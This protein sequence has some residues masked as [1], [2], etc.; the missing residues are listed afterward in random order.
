MYWSRTGSLAD[1]ALWCLMSGLWWVGGW[2]LVTHVF[3]LKPRERLVS[4]LAAGLLL[5]LVLANLLAHFLPLPLTFWLASGLILSAGLGAAA[6]RGRDGQVSPSG[7]LDR[8]DLHAWPLL[9]ALFSLTFLFL[10]IG[11][12]LALFDDYLHL[13]LISVMAA[14][15][16]PPPFYLNPAM[17]MAYHYGLQILAASL[18]RTG[19][20]FPW[21]AWDAS[22]AL[23]IALTLALGWLWVRRIT[24]SQVGATLGAFL[25]TFAG[26]ARWLLL[27]VPPG[28]LLW[29]SNGVQLSNTGADTAPN[30]LKAL[31][32]PWLIDGGGPFP[33]PFAFHNGIFIPVFFELGGTGAIH[34]ATVL[35]LLLLATRH[36]FSAPALLI[37]SLIFAS[38]ALTAE[39]LFVFLWGGIFLAGLLY[40]IANRKQ[41]RRRDHRLLAGWAVILALSGILSVT[42][43]AYLTQAAHSFLLRL[44][45][46]MPAQQGPY[47]YFYFTPRWPPGL[48]SAHLGELSWFNPRQLPVL[49][50]ELGPALWLAPLV[51]I[52]AWRALRRQDWLVAGL[53]IAGL[54]S[55]LVPVFFRY[56][57]ERSATRL[58]ATALWLFVVL[59]F[60]LLWQ[61]YRRARTGARFWLGL[62]YGLAVLGGIVIF[63][64]ELI[65][66]PTPQLTTFISPADALWS[67]MYWRRLPQNSLVFDP[68]SF[69]SVTLF[70]EP[71]LANEGIYTPLPQWEALAEQ[72]DPIA[73]AQAGYDFLYLDERW[74]RHMT[75]N[76]Q[77]AY[78]QPCIRAMPGPSPAEFPRLLD[79]RNC[80]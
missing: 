62:G 8:Q 48:T 15:E 40:W 74:W 58:P 11:R 27:L 68:I 44:Q 5:F 43:G 47:D 65:A 17:P 36:D 1:L 70:G 59:S 63:A 33:F 49:L 18:V 10:L 76:E 23:A 16:I 46:Q 45:G 37:L 56:G 4:G 30:L 34:F 14:G 53:G 3:R 55:L 79:L 29:M 73:I 60:P 50:A 13:P 75:P 71:S 6:W 32:S 39:H 57:Y 2:L 54:L 78:D 80:R 38:L 7:W 41:H 77:K 61:V 20:F 12:G 22:K 31:A 69:R 25:I 51:V 64:V 72:K 52:V 19:G 67:Q 24:R 35:L 28:L 9:L 26:G 21:S 66:I 42:Q